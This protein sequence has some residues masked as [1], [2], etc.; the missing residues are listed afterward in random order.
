MT[1]QHMERVKGF[2]D[3]R[4]RHAPAN[5]QEAT[6]RD[7]WQR[8]LE[9]ERIKEFVAP[10][11]R[12]IDVG[13]GTGYTT[14]Q[15]A[16]LARE[17]LGVDY[18]EAMIQKAVAA[19]STGNRTGAL[20]F[21]AC[22]V[23]GLTPERFGMF[24]LAISERCLI[25]LAGWEEQKRAVANIAAVLKPGGRFVFVEGSRQGRDRLNQFRQEMGLEAMPPVWHNIDFDEPALLD[26]AGEFFHVER[27][28]H[29]GVYDLVAR[30]LHPLLAAPEQPRYDAPINQMGARLALKSQEF[31]DLSRVLFLV[32]KKKSAHEN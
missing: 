24:D 9:I 17:A 25:N 20:S 2:W 4:A 10:S 18:S 29:F 6:H 8:W 11:N 26:Y 14:R 16:P 3:D 19:Q 5:D 1:T 15:I 27:R 21:A 31:G 28:L 32:L 12:V 30:V 22:D 7:V 23:L 13:C